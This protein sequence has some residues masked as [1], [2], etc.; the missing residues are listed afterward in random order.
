MANDDYDR[1]SRVSEFLTGFVRKVGAD[2]VPVVNLALAMRVTGA[3][4]ESALRRGAGCAT[5]SADLEQFDVG[6]FKVSDKGVLGLGFR[7]G[8]IGRGCIRFHHWL[9]ASRWLV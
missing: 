1:S 9:R 7:P 2:V 6:E 8:V 4:V 3:Q 5:F